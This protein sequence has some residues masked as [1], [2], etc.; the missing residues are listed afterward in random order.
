LPVLYNWDLNIRVGVFDLSGLLSYDEDIKVPDINGEAEDGVFEHT[1][2]AS[3][4]S[5]GIMPLMSF[6]ATDN[7]LINL[8][9][10]AGYIF[11]KSFS[12]K[13]EIKEPSW[14]TFEDTGTRTSQ[15]I[16]FGLCRCRRYRL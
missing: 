13:E 9:F 4:M 1:I 14:G 6:H 11:T 5:A 2:D 7:I 8:G 15:C 3:I 16:R 10:R 12:Q